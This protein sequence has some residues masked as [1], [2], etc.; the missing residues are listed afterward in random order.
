MCIRDRIQNTEF[1]S[2]LEGVRSLGAVEC[3]VDFVT[4]AGS[5]R[6]IGLFWGDKFPTPG[7]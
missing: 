5:R 4:Q 3:D 1:R 7:E 6:R 2:L